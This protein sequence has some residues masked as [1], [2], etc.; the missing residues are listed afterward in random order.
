MRRSWPPLCVLVLMMVLPSF[1]A[2]NDGSYYGHGSTVF[3][4]KENRVQMV[5]EVIRI[6][7][8][9]DKRYPQ[10]EW[11][12]DCTFVFQNLSDTPITIQMGFPDD[13]PFPFGGNAGSIHGFETIIKGETIKSTRKTVRPR[14][15][16]H[17]AARLR[18]E[19]PPKPK[20]VDAETKAWREMAKAA[21]KS[22]DLGFSAAYTWTVHFAP[23]ER[24]VVK[25]R[26]RFGGGSTNGPVTICI[27]ERPLPGTAFWH[28]DPEATGFGSGP[29][30]EVRYVVTTGKT[31]VPPIGEATIEIELPPGRAPNHIMPLPPATEVT[32]KVVRWHYKNFRPTQ[33]LAVIFPY[34]MSFD[35]D[36]TDGY[37]DFSS[38][39][40]VKEWLIFAKANGFTP[41]AIGRMRD[42]QA[43][44]FGIRAPGAA[45]P[46]VFDRWRP[47]KVKEARSKEQLT[48]AEREILKLLD[49]GAAPKTP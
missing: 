20:P 7:Y 4:Y 12:A 30:S 35:E 44:S 43:Y 41:E 5:S 32:P 8:T 18:G 11:A 26:Y 22:M 3:A 27:N 15:R 45:E 47:P 36:S 24:L 1:V 6:R 28:K 23:K 46:K 48:E 9:P 29:C 16:H 14:A 17:M 40:Q 31:W 19:P 49:E 39:K 2:A 33:E 25:N 10:G 21:M 38:P 37:L 34:S 42:I 13:P